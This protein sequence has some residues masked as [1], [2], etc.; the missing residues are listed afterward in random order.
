[1][2]EYLD[3]YK[4]IQELRELWSQNIMTWTRLIIPV[5]GVLFGFFSYIGQ[6]DTLRNIPYIWLLPVIGGTI[7]ITAIVTWRVVVHHIDKQIVRMYPRMLE[8]EEKLN[9]ATHTRYY[10]YNLH[11]R[12]KE[13]LADKLKIGFGELKKLH[14]EG[15][16][17]EAQKI[18]ET[19]HS[20]LL[21]VWDKYRHDSVTSRGH[22]IQDGAAG[23]VI[24]VSI[25]ATLVLVKLIIC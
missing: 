1:M 21:K 13:Y 15:F 11:K 24:L 5:G 20:L 22:S 23:I 4:H 9:W 8:L 17:Q 18:Q 19:P 14:Y 12:A 10:Y 25:I 2:N 6:L 3:E 16:E 7:F